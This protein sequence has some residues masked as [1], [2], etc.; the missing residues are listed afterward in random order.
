[1]VFVLPPPPSDLDHSSDSKIDLPSISSSF[2][3][4]NSC[5]SLKDDAIFCLSIIRLLKYS[6][7]QNV[8]YNP[9]YCDYLDYPRSQT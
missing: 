3:H 2:E 4:I 1:M 5:T 6:G 7:S 8:K 9:L